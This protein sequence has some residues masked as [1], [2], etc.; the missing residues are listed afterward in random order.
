MYNSSV[1]SCYRY[2]VDRTVA[3]FHQARPLGDPHKD[4]QSPGHFQSHYAD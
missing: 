1:A 2:E 3:E 4:K